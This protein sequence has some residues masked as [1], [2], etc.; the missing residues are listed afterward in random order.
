[1]L[2]AAKNCKVRSK[3]W[4]S[5]EL[6]GNGVELTQSDKEGNQQ[7][8]HEKCDI[9]SACG[10][11]WT[12]VVPFESWNQGEYDWVEVER[13]ARDAHAQMQKRRYMKLKL[14]GNERN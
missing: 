5:V 4:D 1:M 11:I 3:G 7:G 10:P 12:N 6:L 14:C 9:S 13:S 8:Q 2:N